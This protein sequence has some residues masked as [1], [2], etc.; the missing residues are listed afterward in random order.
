[1]RKIIEGYLYLYPY[2]GDDIFV[3]PEKIDIKNW[4]DLSRIHFDVWSDK[5]GI[6]LL[7]LLGKLNGKK[8]RVIIEDKKITIK[9]IS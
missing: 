7:Y 4:D 6:S 3:H 2:A 8:V 9:V 5:K 1:V